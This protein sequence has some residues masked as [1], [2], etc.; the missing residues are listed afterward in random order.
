M[1]LLSRENEFPLL[2]DYELSY[3]EILV[4]KTGWLYC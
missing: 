2:F 4:E 1:T 3:I